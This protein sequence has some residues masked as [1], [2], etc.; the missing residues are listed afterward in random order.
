MAFQ[1]RTIPF[2]T[3]QCGRSCYICSV[4]SSPANGLSQP[5]DH[6]TLQN[7][8]KLVEYK[9]NDLITTT[10]LPDKT[11]KLLVS[12]SIYAM[13]DSQ[14]GAGSLGKRTVCIIQNVPPLRSGSATK[15]P[16]ESFILL[17]DVMEHLV[18]ALVVAQHRTAA[19]EDAGRGQLHKIQLKARR[20]HIFFTRVNHMND[21]LRNERLSQFNLCQTGCQA[22]PARTSQ[23]HLSE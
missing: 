14:A 16:A 10:I 23:T 19:M 12:K 22:T 4:R 18:P 7:S 6:H 5:G 21:R 13:M 9:N 15:R 11:S 1:L 17:R 8:P 2:G 20:P 3:I